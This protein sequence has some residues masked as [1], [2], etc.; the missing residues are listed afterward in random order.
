[1]PE[2]VAGNAPGWWYGLSNLSCSADGS[3]LL[4]S[5]SGTGYICVSK[6][7]GRTWAVT[8]TNG[9]DLRTTHIT[10]DGSM[11]LGISGSAL[12]ETNGN[13]GI[14]VNAGTL[15]AVNMPKLFGGPKKEG[16]VAGLIFPLFGGS[17]QVLPAGIAS[18]LSAGSDGY[19]VP[20]Y[21]NISYNFV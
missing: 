5:S 2:P 12:A 8:A 15:F 19:N 6:D 11:Q 20:G 3:V 17:Y 9:A 4:A 10:R 21:R 1:M 13:L 16:G 18:K 14:Y 7:F